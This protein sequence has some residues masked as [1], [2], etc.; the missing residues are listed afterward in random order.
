MTVRVANDF[1]T[2]AL[3][4]RE[5]LV[6]DNKTQKEKIRLL[7]QQIEKLNKQRK[8]I[9]NTLLNIIIAILYFT[10]MQQT[11]TQQSV[12]SSV[13]QEMASRR[14][15]LAVNRQD[16]RLSVKS[17]IETIENNKQQVC[18]HIISIAATLDNNLFSLIPGQIRRS[19]IQL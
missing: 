5:Q 19:W 14:S 9:L 8:P 13:Q 17:L 4:A 2:E 18:S 11:E 3:S 6:L 15:K 16:S 12:L 10:E 7:E 1:K